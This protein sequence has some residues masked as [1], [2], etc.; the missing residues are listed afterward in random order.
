MIDY[1]VRV[2][3]VLKSFVALSIAVMLKVDVEDFEDLVDRIHERNLAVDAV[4]VHNFET[5]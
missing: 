3:E 4:Y 5:T 1:F 2:K